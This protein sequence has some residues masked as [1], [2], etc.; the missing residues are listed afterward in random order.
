MDVNNQYVKDGCDELLDCIED[1]LNR[2]VE[3]YWRC[4]DTD[5][6]ME[7]VVE[8]DRRVKLALIKKLVEGLE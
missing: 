4:D 8:F 7:A 5:D 2:L 6:C 1:N 3:L